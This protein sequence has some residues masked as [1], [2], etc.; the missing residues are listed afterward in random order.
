MIAQAVARRAIEKAAAQTFEE[1]VQIEII[2]FLNKP[3]R[4]TFLPQAE[5]SRKV[6]QHKIRKKIEEPTIIKKRK[7]QKSKNR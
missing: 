5:T 1:N 3:G 7:N 2:K 4:K 6:F